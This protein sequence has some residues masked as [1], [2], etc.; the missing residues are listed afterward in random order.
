MSDGALIWCMYSIPLPSL[1]SIIHLLSLSPSLLPSLPPSLC[2][3]CHSPTTSPSLPPPPS[4]QGIFGD[5]P[6]ELNE[7]CREVQ[8]S[9]VGQ[10]IM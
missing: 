5:Y 7:I 9:L 6:G 3:L 4:L 1:R 2:S 10:T 8:L